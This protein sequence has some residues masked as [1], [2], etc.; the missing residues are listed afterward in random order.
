[1]FGKRLNSQGSAGP[2]GTPGRRLYAIGDVHGC[3]AEMCALMVRI[4]Q[5]HRARPDAECFVVFLGDL[6]D[7]GPHSRDVIRHL[8]DRPPAFAKMLVLKGNHEEMMLR[9]LRGEP[10]LIKDWLKHGGDTCARSYG[11][12]P[13][14][15]L[16]ENV[17]TLEH[18]LT[19]FIPE[20]H[21][22]FL[23]GC[24]DQVRFGDYLLVHAGVRPGVALEAQ[25]GHDLRWIRGEFLETDRS[26][27][28]VVVH[29]HT[30]TDQVVQKPNRIGVDTG[31][32]KTGV[33]SAVRLEGADRS[34]LSA[35]TPKLQA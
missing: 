35:G 12:D 6:I 34:I 2:Q 8:I 29:G 19:R 18:L 9:S 28:A 21:L 31:V 15:L 17:D 27:G 3:Y 14:R 11:L 1:M 13:A 30:V 5:D 23:D 20:E 7:R 33:L 4:E 10:E 16:T 22:D 25:S 26:F 32:Y 24:V